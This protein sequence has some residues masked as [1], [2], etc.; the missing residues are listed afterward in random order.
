MTLSTGGLDTETATS[1]G[2]DKEE[3]LEEDENEDED[4]GEDGPF[5]VTGEEDE[6][7]DDDGDDEVVW[8]GFVLFNNFYLGSLLIVCRQRTCSRSHKHPYHRQ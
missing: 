4:G 3:E 1:E 6:D 8:D 5:E 7:Q 2:E